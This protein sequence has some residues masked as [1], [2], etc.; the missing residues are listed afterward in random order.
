MLQVFQSLSK[1]CNMLPQ[2]DVALKV[3]LSTM[4]HDIDFERALKIGSCNITFSGFLS[5]EK[6]ALH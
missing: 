3:A 2:R 6:K 5:T 4:L 1:T